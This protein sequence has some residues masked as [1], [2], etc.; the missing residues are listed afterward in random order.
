MTRHEWTGTA[1]CT[2]ARAAQLL[3]LSDKTLR[4]AIAA[5]ELRTEQAPRGRTLL[6]P[7]AELQRYAAVRGLALPAGASMPRP[8]QVILSELR[9]LQE[10][11]S[12]LH[13]ELAASLE[14]LSTASEHGT[15]PGGEAFVPWLRAQARPA[16]WE[17]VV[18][19]AEAAE[20]PG[21]LWARLRT[22]VLLNLHLMGPAD[23][24]A[25]AIARLQD[26]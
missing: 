7:A 9:G 22:D 20:H 21:E 24:A 11:V 26:G 16:D 14:Q 10:R 4:R 17:R 13:A 19:A 5:G 23:A 1:A 18:Q 6:I 2:L 3:G 15:L 8:P 25:A 12:L